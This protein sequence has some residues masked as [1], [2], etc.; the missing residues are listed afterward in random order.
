M[1]LEAPLQLSVDEAAALLRDG[2]CILLDVREP[3]EVAV[4]AVAGALEVPLGDLPR[5]IADLPDDLPI[6]VMCHHGM[7][8]MQA[9]M[10]LRAQGLAQV[11]NVAGGIDAWSLH[12]DHTVPRY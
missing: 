10:W 3:W 9:T 2:M 8:S 7:R 1:S 5:R 11:S 6:L 4:A 12:V